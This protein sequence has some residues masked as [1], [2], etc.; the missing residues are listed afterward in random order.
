MRSCQQSLEREKQ[1]FSNVFLEFSFIN[2]SAL[3]A[4]R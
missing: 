1:K 3:F 2:K 4:F